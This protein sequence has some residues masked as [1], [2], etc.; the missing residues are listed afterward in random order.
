MQR[1][2]LPTGAV[3]H[4]DAFD[5]T[6]AAHGYAV[7][8]DGATA[9]LGSGAPYYTVQGRT[10]ISKSATTAAN[11]RFYFEAVFSGLVGGVGI[12]RLNDPARANLYNDDSFLLSGYGDLYSFGG[13]RKGYAPNCSRST[14]T[15]YGCLLDM[16]AGAVSFFVDGVELGAVTHD[17]LRSG[18]WWTTV[19]FRS[20]TVLGFRR[21]ITF[22]DAIGSHACSLEARMCVT[23]GI[24]LGCSLTSYWLP[25]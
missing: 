23:N 22:E 20:G 16:D 8:A 10:P 14:G 18:E 13:S 7:S 6:K 15:L 11:K 24:P 1:V 9:T 17:C 12:A 3:W 21:K 25:R 5:P 19:T 4:A 2:S